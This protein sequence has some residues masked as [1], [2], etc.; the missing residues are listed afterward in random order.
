MKNIFT[1]NLTSAVIIQ[2]INT[3]SPFN[4]L[5]NTV[6]ELKVYGRLFIYYN[7]NYT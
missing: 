1:L 5:G 4:F 6:L 7:T 2:H 3:L